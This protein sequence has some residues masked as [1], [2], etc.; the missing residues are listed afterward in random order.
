[1]ENWFFGQVIKLK[2]LTKFMNYE[3]REIKLYKE[4]KP[5]WCS[6][7]RAIPFPGTG[8]YEEVKQSGHL[9][10]DSFDD[11][12]VDKVMCRTEAL[13]GEDIDKYA[14]LLGNMVSRKKLKQLLVNPAKL[15]VVL[16]DIRRNGGIKRGM[17]RVWQLRR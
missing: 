8:F 4:I 14:V 10:I 1:M 15:A 11:I 3:E 12:E 6:F 13:T 16:N 17:K 5:D 2:I 7:T 9:L